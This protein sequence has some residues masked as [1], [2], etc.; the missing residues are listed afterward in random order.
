MVLRLAAL[1]SSTASLRS[2]PQPEVGE[3]AG[4]GAHVDQ[5]V[6]DLGPHRRW[7]GVDQPLAGRP[8][9]RSDL[10][11]DHDVVRAFGLWMFDCGF[12][13]PV[14]AIGLGAQRFGA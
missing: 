12:N 14:I 13:R 6:L 3:R 8:A 2:R 4:F 5:R 1:S 11:A 7:P 10:V 9:R